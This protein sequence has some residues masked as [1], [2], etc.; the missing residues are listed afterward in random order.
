MDWRIV[1]VV[2]PIALAA[3]WALFNIGRAAL[4]QVQAFLNKD[5]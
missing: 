2:A 4:G 3:S 5:A 1:V